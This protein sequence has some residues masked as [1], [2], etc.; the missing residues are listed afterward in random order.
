MSDSLLLLPSLP[1]QFNQRMHKKKQTK[2]TQDCKRLLTTFSGIFFLP[3][4][5]NVC[6][7][8][9]C[10]YLCILQCIAILRWYFCVCYFFFIVQNGDAWKIQMLTSCLL[11]SPKLPLWNK[12]FMRKMFLQGGAT[13]CWVPSTLCSSTMAAMGPGEVARAGSGGT[14]ACLSGPGGAYTSASSSS[15]EQPTGVSTLKLVFLFCFSEF[16]PTQNDQR[17]FWP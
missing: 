11:A 15:S 6:H 7:L 1:R 13:L 2:K 17:S 12:S 16:C 8:P 9:L 10:S 5:C 3:V 14:S 4:R